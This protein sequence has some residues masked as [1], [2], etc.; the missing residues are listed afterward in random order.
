MLPRFTF[1]THDDV[2]WNN[3]NA[4][5]AIKAFVRLRNV[6]GGTSTVKGMEEYLILLSISQTCKNK[7]VSF[8]E[9]FR[10]Q[11][12]DIDEFASRR[13]HRHALPR[14]VSVEAAH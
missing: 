8:L 13:Q 1:L 12:T 6:M 9:F 4:E 11:E 10:S 7:G 3:I 2:S 5:H 14:H